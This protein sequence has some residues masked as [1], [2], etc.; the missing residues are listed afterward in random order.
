MP[1]LKSRRA[2]DPSTPSSAG[3][4]PS[5]TRRNDSSESPGPGRSSATPRPGRGRG[6]DLDLDAEPK[7]REEMSIEE[8][9]ALLEG[10]E[11]IDELPEDFDP[12]NIDYKRLFPDL[13]LE[14]MPIINDI[15]EEDVKNLLD[16]NYLKRLLKEVNS[17]A[18]NL[19]QIPESQTE[20][21]RIKEIKKVRREVEDQARSRPKKTLEEIEAMEIPD[22]IMPGEK[23]PD[24]PWPEYTLNEFRKFRD[25][26]DP[27][28]N[29]EPKLHRRFIDKIREDCA[30]LGDVLRIMGREPNDEEKKLL[31]DN[32]GYVKEQIDQLSE[33]YAMV[34]AVNMAEEQARTGNYGAELTPLNVYDKEMDKWT[35]E[36][37]AKSEFEKYGNVP[38]FIEFKRTV[39]E[40]FYDTPVPPPRKWFSN[41][42]EDDDDIGI[43]AVKISYKDPLTLKTFEKPVTN[44]PCNHSYERQAIFDLITQAEASTAARQ[45]TGKI[46]CPV[47]G[48]SHKVG[49]DTLFVDSVL[50]RG[51]KR[52]KEM[53]EIRKMEEELNEEFDWGDIDPDCIDEEGNYHPE[54]S[55]RPKKTATEGADKDK[56]AKGIKK[57][58]MSQMPKKIV[59]DDDYE[60]DDE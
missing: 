28:I 58:M 32:E 50:V 18:D 15:S 45:R 1:T 3:E 37:N 27:N 6:I 29:E 54:W 19:P 48:C 10:I 21:D 11:D 33:F 31:A 57:E 23:I 36:Y 5:R 44:R 41:D 49:K 47:P 43:S 53:E 4:G 52:H 40:A 24:Y 30:K 20:E 13:D 34:D 14:N 17:L 39:W 46:P 9:A 26:M 22:E 42:D 7:D 60:E 8:I 56:E 35:E 12:D 59:L 16:T 51:L 25:S 2:R 38:E 55:K